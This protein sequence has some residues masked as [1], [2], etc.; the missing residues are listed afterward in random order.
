MNGFS[1]HKTVH[2]SEFQ[3]KG[4]TEPAGPI[5]TLVPEYSDRTG[6]RYM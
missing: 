2:R 1:I 5:N 4:N 3:V 6:D